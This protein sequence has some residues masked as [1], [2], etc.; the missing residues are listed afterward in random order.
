MWIITFFHLKGT[1]H[2]LKIKVISSAKVLYRMI[3]V[4]YPKCI[5][6]P[7]RDKPHFLCLPFPFIW[8]SSR[9][10]DGSGVQRICGGV[11]LKGSQHYPKL[12]GHA[13]AQLY[14]K[15]RFDIQRGARKRAILGLKCGPLAFILDGSLIPLSFKRWTFNPCSPGWNWMPCLSHTHL[16]RAGFVWL[17][18]SRD[19]IWGV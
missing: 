10:V 3:R 12:F 11:D 17:G 13:V 18:H 6:F 14:D 5:P 4:F 1:I 2:L 16:W 19:G 9:Y 8:V 7:F 15:N